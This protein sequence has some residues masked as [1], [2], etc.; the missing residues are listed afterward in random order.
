MKPLLRLLAVMILP[1]FLITAR[2]LYGRPAAISFQVNS[3]LDEVDAD[4]ADGLCLTAAGTCTLRAAVMQ[5]NMISNS[6]VEINLPAGEFKLTRLK[7]DPNGADVGDLN[8]TDPSGDINY[9]TW[10]RGAGAA[11]TIIDANQ[12]DRAFTVDPLRYAYIEGVTIRNGLVD[13]N[14]GETGG[15]IFNSGRLILIDS[16]IRDS[17]A[18]WGG[19]VSNFGTLALGGVTI[20]GNTAFEG[21]GLHNFRIFPEDTSAGILSIDNSTISGNYAGTGGGIASRSDLFLT[22]STITGN[23]A[24]GEGGGIYNSGVA[25]IYNATIVFN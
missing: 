5:S 10:I 15:G 6:D 20:Q 11:S 21:G 7:I 17:L 4:L 19:G 2:T 18:T 3:P 22:N 23:T 16:T 12:L 13:T 9:I 8:L 24:G 25:N 1:V 14:N